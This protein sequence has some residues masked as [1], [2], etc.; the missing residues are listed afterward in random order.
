MTAIHLS[1]RS[2][3]INIDEWKNERTNEVLFILA[4]S[5]INPHIQEW[6]E[7]R[8]FPDETRLYWG[9]MGRVHAS[10][11]PYLLPLDDWGA[12]EKD[13]AFQPNW[14]LLLRLNPSVALSAHAQQALMQHLREWTMIESPDEEQMLLRLSDFEVLKVLLSA[15]NET[16]L[17]SLFGPIAE[18]AYWQQGVEEVEVLSLIT[19]TEKTLPHRSPQLLSAPQYQALQAFAHR[20]QHQKYARHLQAHHP[21]V[22]QWDEATQMAFIARNV[23]CARFHHFSIEKDIVRY[24]SLAVILGELF[25]EDIWAKEL[26]KTRRIEGTSSRMDALFQRVL[27]EMDKGTKS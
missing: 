7:G 21:E 19:R 12:F 3:L 6:M 22:Q 15:S 11:S 8:D 10:I 20:H 13:I 5:A 23:E 27:E 26:L 9:E 17:N 24:L 14:G 2:Q 1:I 4:E 16:E 25:H 18:F